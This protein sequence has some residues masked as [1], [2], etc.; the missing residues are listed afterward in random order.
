MDCTLVKLINPVNYK[1]CEEVS[2][3]SMFMTI[4]NG[5]LTEDVA[6]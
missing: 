5:S 3:E 2:A 1:G 4:S 6:S